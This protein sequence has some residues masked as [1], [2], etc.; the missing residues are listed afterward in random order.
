MEQY[1]ISKGY[2]IPVFHKAYWL[3]LTTQ[4]TGGRPNWY[5]LEPNANSPT[6]D[7][8]YKHWGMYQVGTG[9][10]PCQGS[11]PGSCAC[12]CMPALT[13]QPALAVHHAAQQFKPS[14]LN[15]S[16]Q[17]LNSREPNSLYP[18][19]ECAVGNWT[20]TFKSAWGWADVRCSNKYVYMCK[21]IRGWPPASWS[22]LI[23]P[24]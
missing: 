14:H 8:S 5:W 21:I 12:A 17:P 22:C 19:E 1:F 3:G 11:S 13:W 18:P 16:P 20:E 9:A 15:A 2:L 10:L 4:K 7:E 24:L 23:R 6:D